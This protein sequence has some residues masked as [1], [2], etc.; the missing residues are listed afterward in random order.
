MATT[1]TTAKKEEVK[2]ETQAAAAAG[3]STRDWF[4]GLAMSQLINDRAITERAN[5]SDDAVKAK[6]SIVAEQAYKYADEM[7]AKS[8]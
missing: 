6:A 5:R 1:T 8:K 7:L 2:K 4:A 3:I